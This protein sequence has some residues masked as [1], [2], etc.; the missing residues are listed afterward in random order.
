[1]QDAFAK[2]F[3]ISYPLIYSTTRKGHIAVVHMEGSKS[4]IIFAGLSFKPSVP[5]LESNKAPLELTSVV[6]VSH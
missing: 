1:M 5:S 3:L 4:P 6:S 2:A